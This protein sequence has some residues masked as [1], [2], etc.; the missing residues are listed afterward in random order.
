MREIRY[1]ASYGEVIV[2]WSD[3]PGYHPLDRD[4]P[5]DHS[6]DWDGFAYVSIPV[7]RPYNQNGDFF[8]CRKVRT[9]TATH[10]VHGRYPI[11][12]REVVPDLGWRIPTIPYPASNCPKGLNLPCPTVLPR[13]AG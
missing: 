8:W 6:I 1:Q 11:M 7:L 2:N 10:W 4:P 5:A 9:D 13:R 3:P 12:P